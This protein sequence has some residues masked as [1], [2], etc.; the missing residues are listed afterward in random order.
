MNYMLQ[1]SVIWKLLSH[2]SCL[3]GM[4]SITM[5]AKD[6]GGFCIVLERNISCFNPNLLWD[7]F[8]YLLLSGGLIIF[9]SRFLSSLL[10]L[11]ILS[12]LLT[13]NSHL[14]LPPND[15]ELPFDPCCLVILVQVAQD[16]ETE[17]KFQIDLLNQL[18]N[19]VLLFRMPISLFLLFYFWFAW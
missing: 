6:S 18:V 9:W 10:R 11:H 19:H 1:K 13:S 3:G 14:F 16:I 15:K 2:M 17:A 7:H 8:W 4:Q 12:Y 5:S